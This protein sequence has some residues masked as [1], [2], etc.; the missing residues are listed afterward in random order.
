M[1]AAQHLS[2]QAE[3]SQISTVASAA[4][5]NHRAFTSCWPSIRPPSAPSLFWPTPFPLLEQSGG[6]IYI[7]THT[8]I[9]DFWSVSFSRW[10]VTAV[11][12]TA[13]IGTLCVWSAHCVCTNNAALAKHHQI[14]TRITRQHNMKR[15]TSFNPQM[16]HSLSLS[17]RPVQPRTWL[18]PISKKKKNRHQALTLHSLETQSSQPCVRQS[19]V[20]YSFMFICIPSTSYYLYKRPATCNAGSQT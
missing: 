9:H 14:T 6:N 12:D 15:N 4:W 18:L 16:K 3:G 5:G 19:E 20:E 8:Y 1:R 17:N 13:V 2:A 7:C 10:L 11:C